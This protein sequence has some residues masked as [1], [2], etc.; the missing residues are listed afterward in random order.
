[1]LAEIAI[2]SSLK[3]RPYP[4]RTTII[5]WNMSGLQLKPIWGPKLLLLWRPCIATH[6]DRHARVRSATRTKHRRL[7]VILLRIKGAEVGVTK[8]GVQRQV[9]LSLPIVLDEESKLIFTIV[10]TVSTR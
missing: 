4:P 1:M 2:S 6:P 3:F 7:Q 9:W 5:P 10:L 8:P